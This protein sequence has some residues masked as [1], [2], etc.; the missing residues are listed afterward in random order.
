MRLLWPAPPLAQSRH[1]QQM[2]Q[3]Q[4]AGLLLLV[5]RMP[6]A[7]HKAAAAAE[8]AVQGVLPAEQHHLEG[9]RLQM[10]AS[11]A[12]AAAVQG[13]LHSSCRHSSWQSCVEAVTA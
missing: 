8:R 2:P 6:L 12:A 11:T 10:V 1:S 13:C 4:P 9:R 5:L 7:Q 3:R